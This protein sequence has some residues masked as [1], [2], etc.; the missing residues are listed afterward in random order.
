MNSQRLQYLWLCVALNLLLTGCFGGKAPAV[1]AESRQRAETALTRGVRAEQKGNYPEA[2][3]L[4]AEALATSS[5]IEDYPART[6][7][8]INLA[9][10]HRLRHDLPNAESYI[11]QALVL[12]TKDSPL[13]AEATH[14]KALLELTKGNPATALEWAQ[15]SIAAEQGNLRGTRRNLASRIQVVLGNWSAADALA[16]AA[17]DENR[18]AHQAEEEANSLRIMGIVARNDKKYSQGEQ[19][20]QEAL[21]IDKRIGK[22]SKIAADLEELAITADR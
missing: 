9:R 15:K 16:R 5:S 19:F 11:D 20:L 13:F 21:S 6:T 12:L 18:S 2:E 17:L 10:L 7:A 3:K 22:S 8:L 1:R 4:L 14:E